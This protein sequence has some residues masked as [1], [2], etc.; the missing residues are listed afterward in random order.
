M[1][2][3]GAGDGAI[4]EIMKQY[5]KQVYA[6]EASQVMQWRLRQK[7]ITVLPI[8][9]WA[10]KNFDLICALN[11]LDRHFDPKS[12]LRD[13]HK[14]AL[15]SN[16]LVLLAIVLPWSQYVEFNIQNSTSIHAVDYITLDGTTF[17]QQ[18]SSLVEK[19]LIPAGFQVL[20]WTKLPYLCE[21]DSYRAYY[22]LTDSVFVLRA[23]P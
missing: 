6:T 16:A 7:E 13:L 3:L 15:T 8:D 1:I 23:I 14:T 21:G 2:D 10:D 11:L 5:Y 12:L 4:T 19:L 17:E 9:G 20:R 22:K 18:A